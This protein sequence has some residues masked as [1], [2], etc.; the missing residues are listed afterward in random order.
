[1]KIDKRRNYL[2]GLDT[3]TCNAYIDETGKL[4]LDDSLV[5]DI[6]YIVTD[7]HGTIYRQRSF[8]VKEVF[9]GM[10]E[11]MT[12]AYYANKIPKYLAD[13][14]DG[15]REVK[16]IWEIREILNADMEEFD[17]KTVFAHNARFD[18]NVLRNTVRYLSGSACRDFFPYN[19]IIWDTLKMS[20][21]VFGNRKAYKEFCVKNG[22]MTK[23]KTPQCRFTAEILYRYLTLNAQFAESHTGL[24][25]VLIETEIL[26][27]CFKAHKKMRKTLY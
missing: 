3:E 4:N 27:N 25:D 7:K 23:H 13:I 8:I 26:R 5:Y 14:N 10:A 9:F 24:E 15:T 6:G 20:R 11:V 1:M 21:D 22:Y 16:S 18:N 2:I 12:S 17:T 19:T